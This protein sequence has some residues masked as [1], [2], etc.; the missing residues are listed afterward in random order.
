MPSQP[1]RALTF[2]DTVMLGG[3]ITVG[4]CG[5]LLTLM[6]FIDQ[7]VPSAGWQRILVTLGA[8]WGVLAQ[9]GATA[10]LL[11]QNYRMGKEITRLREA[12]LADDQRDGG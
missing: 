10:A 8:A 3:M 2:R 1:F 11:G 12:G 5:L 7:L 9:V 6:F 4:G